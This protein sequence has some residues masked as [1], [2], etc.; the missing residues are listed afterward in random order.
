MLL[1]PQDNVKH[2]NIKML[3]INYHFRIS[4]YKKKILNHT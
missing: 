4:S 1:I 3:K 2:Q